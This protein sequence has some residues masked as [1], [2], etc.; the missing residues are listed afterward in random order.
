MH[1]LA[2]EH[3]DD[4]YPEFL[5]EWYRSDLTRSQQKITSLQKDVG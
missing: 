4:P 1:L 2:D 5:P 3:P